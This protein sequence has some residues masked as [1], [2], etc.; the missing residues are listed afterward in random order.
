[1]LI[2]KSEIFMKNNNNLIIFL[3]KGEKIKQMILNFDIKM[4]QD[5]KTQS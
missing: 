1:M 4:F 3:N 5:N 2:Q